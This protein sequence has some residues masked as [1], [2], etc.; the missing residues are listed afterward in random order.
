MSS[1]WIPSWREQLLTTSMTWR[2]GKLAK[3]T[4]MIRQLE[5]R[6]RILKLQTIEG[7]FP[8]PLTSLCTADRGYDGV[9][10]C[11]GFTGETSTWLPRKYKCVRSRSHYVH[12]TCTPMYLKK[13]KKVCTQEE[14]YPLRRRHVGLNHFQHVG[15]DLVQVLQTANAVGGQGPAT[16]MTQRRT[17]LIHDAEGEVAFIVLI[18]MSIFPIFSTTAG[19]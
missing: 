16:L 19:A 8:E 10:S 3:K 5:A 12:E 17:S 18:S 9:W 15:R 14:G 2:V 6:Y 1:K 7:W 13:K 11:A 4:T